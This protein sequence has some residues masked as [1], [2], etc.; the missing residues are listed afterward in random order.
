MLN[1]TTG[2]GMYGFSASDL[3]ELA[4]QGVKPWDEDA[5][6]MFFSIDRFLFSP[7]AQDVLDVLNDNYY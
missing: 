2:G 6:V 5:Q 3:E 7:L 1:A 4:C